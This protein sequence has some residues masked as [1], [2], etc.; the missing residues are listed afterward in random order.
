MIK[1][2]L[3]KKTLS[4]LNRTIII[5]LYL[6]I[7]G[8]SPSKKN[9]ENVWIST[10]SEDAGLYLQLLNDTLDIYPFLINNNNDTN[11]IDLKKIPVI[12]QDG[13]NI[14]VQLPG[15]KIGSITYYGQDSIVF[16]HNTLYDVC[17]N[18]IELKLKDIENFEKFIDTY[19]TNKRLI[20]R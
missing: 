17:Y 2:L 18:T 16:C 3:D 10:V 19:L 9:S 1:N 4:L 15:S 12:E 8:C 13:K 14:K 5:L 20:M 11:I 6:F 7:L